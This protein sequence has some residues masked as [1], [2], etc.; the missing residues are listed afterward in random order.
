MNHKTQRIAIKEADIDEKIIPV[1]KWLNSFH[2]VAT[3]FCC[4]G[5]KVGGNDLQPYVI[6]SCYETEELMEILKV[7]RDFPSDVKCEVD[8]WLEQFP[9]RYRLVFASAKS[10]KRFVEFRATFV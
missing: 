4:Q 5:G 6:F 1:V 8:W 9:L 3:F 2:S 10:L 7:L